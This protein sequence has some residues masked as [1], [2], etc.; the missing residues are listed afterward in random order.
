MGKSHINSMA[1]KHCCWGNCTN[2]S[3]YPERSPAETYF[4][5]FPKPGKI[6]DSMTQWEKDRE[7]SK[8]E[9]AKIWAHAC[10]RE[11]FTIKNIKKDTYICSQH[12]VDNHGPTEKDPHPILATLS[13]KKLATKKKKR[14]K[15]KRAFV[16]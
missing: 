15:T 2:D 12:F 14:T 6:K 4:I 16:S 13:E 9:K 7:C 3:R 1:T 10:G 8:T 11:G 5:R